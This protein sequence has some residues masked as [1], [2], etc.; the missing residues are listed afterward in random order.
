MARW[1][2]S[3]AD[4]QSATYSDK[5]INSFVSHQNK[6]QTKRFDND[7]A[8]N[9]NQF[10]NLL[11]SKLCK[12]YW[13]TKRIIESRIISSSCF[14]CCNNQNIYICF[15]SKYSFGMLI[16]MFWIGGNQRCSTR[17]VKRRII[18]MPFFSRRMFT[19]H[20]HLLRWWD[21]TEQVSTQQSIPEISVIH[22]CKRWTHRYA[23][24]T[25]ACALL[26]TRYAHNHYIYI[27]YSVLYHFW[28]KNLLLA[29]PRWYLCLINETLLMERTSV[30]AA[31]TRNR[32]R[33]HSFDKCPIG[34][35]IISLRSSKFYK[36]NQRWKRFGT[37]NPH[38]H[39]LIWL[40]HCGAYGRMAPQRNHP[41]RPK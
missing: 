17:T 20:L 24:H 10:I 32:V 9:A 3:S 7:N 35:L 18:T 31:P 23:G 29:F 6:C 8:A 22:S 1:Q 39:I 28:E 30:C 4:C 2:W 11:I 21:R 41:N 15:F 19:M 37:E 26:Y 16:V 38:T 27:V 5:W 12:L 14:V 13:Q 25:A 40:I 36:Q 34:Q 33:L